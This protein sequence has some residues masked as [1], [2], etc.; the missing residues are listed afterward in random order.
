MSEDRSRQRLGR[1]LA[2]LIG[3]EGRSGFQA[4]RREREPDAVVRPDRE[5]ALAAVTANPNNP[6][7]TFGEEDIADLTQSVKKHGIV[8]PL[9][10]RPNPDKANSYEIVAGE[11]RFRAARAAGL[12]NIPVVV[13]DI[14]DRQSIEIALIENVQRTDLNAVEEALAYE[15][16]IDEHG[17]TQA[18]L[19]ETLAKS[20]SHVANMLR[21]LKLPEGVREM[22]VTGALSPGAART[23]IGADDP[24]AMARLIVKEGLSVREAED[25]ARGTANSGEAVTDLGAGQ[26]EEPPSRVRTP[27]ADMVDLE[28]RLADHLAM[29][30]SLKGK[31]GK[32][33]LKIDYRSSE[34]LEDI[35]ARLGL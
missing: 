9:L 6:R 27:S 23:L 1:G 15:R 5:V 2:A 3:T 29:N 14:D 10:V 20:R 26:G 22:I 31:R 17:Y 7:R 28:Q 4:S 32:G 16:L 18:D 35:L 12:E 19:A 21:L 11:R 34:E 25:L 8:Q 13:R 33:S 30:V 24:E